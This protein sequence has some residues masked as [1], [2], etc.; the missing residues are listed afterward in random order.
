LVTS[1]KTNCKIISFL[2]YKNL[3]LKKKFVDVDGLSYVCK[4]ME[5]HH[6]KNPITL[7]LFIL[8]FQKI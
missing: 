5:I 3:K 1:P 4:M 8:N 7:I 6:T 2:K